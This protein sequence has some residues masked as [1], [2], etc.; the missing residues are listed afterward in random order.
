MFADAGGLYDRFEKVLG[1]S[2][3]RARSSDLEDCNPSVAGETEEDRKEGANK[4]SKE[5]WP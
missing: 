2:G 4:L 3:V 1:V 5:V